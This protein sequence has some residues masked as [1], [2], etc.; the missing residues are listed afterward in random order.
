MGF[1]G[2]EGS[3]RLCKGGTESGRLVGKLS[4]SERGWSLEQ[5]CYQHGH[6]VQRAK[7]HTMALPPETLGSLGWGGVPG[8]TM[9]EVR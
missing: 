5:A 3:D 4:Q 1:Q 2:G 6:T 7:D 8:G 9:K